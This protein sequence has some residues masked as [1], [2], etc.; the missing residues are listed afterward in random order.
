MSAAGGPAP[1]WEAWRADLAGARSLGDLRLRLRSAARALRQHLPRR[2]TASA[3]WSSLGLRVVPSSDLEAD[4]ACMYRHDGPI[5]LLRSDND[6]RRQKFTTAHEV[7]HL[8]LGRVRD[9]GHVRLSG[10]IEEELCD[11]FAT[12]LLLPDGEV[13]SFLD[14]RGGVPS[15]RTVL[16]IAGHFALNL[17][18]CILAL[19]RCWHDEQRI[20]L[21]AEKRGH[22]SRPEELAYRVSASA[23]H[24]FKLIPRDKR[25]HSIG[26]G[27][28]AQ[29]AEEAL[30]AEAQEMCSDAQIP[31]WA[32]TSSRRSGSIGGQVTWNA[33]SLPNG[34][35]IALLDLTK[36]T[37]SWSR[38]RSPQASS[39]QVGRAG[40]SA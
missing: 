2:S 32:P 38:P 12:S 1:S 28:L 30:A 11:E 19:N 37:L 9:A 24:P 31:F 39:S 26:L 35:L 13:Q 5:V 29:W 27:P 40:P 7:G 15:P 16:D 8:L 4:G 25:L 20:L 33:L 17:R 6:S 10:A 22:P 3:Q 23:G 21:V 18:P 14:G 34:V 36:A